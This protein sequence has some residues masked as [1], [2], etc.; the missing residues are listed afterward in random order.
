[1][2]LQKR[3]IIILLFLFLYFLGYT[4]ADERLPEPEQKEA[5]SENGI[6]C[7]IADPETDTTT[8]YELMDG[9]K[10]KLWTIT[11]WV[12]FFSVSNEGVL[13]EKFEGANLLPLN[14]KED[15]PMIIFY[16]DGNVLNQ[17]LLNEIIQ[18]FSKLQRTISHYAWGNFLRTD[19]DGTVWIETVEGKTLS[20]QPYDVKAKPFSLSPIT[21][22]ATI[23]VIFILG[24][25]Y[26]SHKK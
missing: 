19:S 13:I 18:D 9:N 8:L 12:R 17:V 10:T 2:H 11:H 1:M 23:V 25:I 4:Y 20:F 24:M 6:F 14:Y 22:L 16:K 26:F 21:V 5:C 15:K 7:A 3:F